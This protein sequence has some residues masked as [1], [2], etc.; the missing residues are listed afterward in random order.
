MHDA[1][2]EIPPSLLFV[3]GH[4]RRQ[5]RASHLTADLEFLG[6]A[7]TATGYRLLACA[8]GEY[9]GLVRDAA[10]S[11]GI[12]GELLDVADPH[13]WA[14]L[15]EYEA[16]DAGTYRREVIDLADG[17]HAQAYLY[18]APDREI[19]PDAGPDWLISPLRRV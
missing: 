19:L 8:G 16:V 12:V 15:D 14:V 2:T 18:T 10:A 13:R 5:D 1:R 11:G 17:R 6:A 3:Y 4:L 7:Q 9:P